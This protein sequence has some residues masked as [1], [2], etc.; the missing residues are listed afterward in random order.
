MLYASKNR[1]WHRRHTD[2]IEM[3]TFAGAVACIA[4][5]AVVMVLGGLADYIW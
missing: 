3:F 4:I 5:A 2:R 1:G